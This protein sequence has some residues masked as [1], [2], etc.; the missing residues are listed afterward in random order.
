MAPVR[1]SERLHLQVYQLVLPGFELLLWPWPSSEGPSLT[2]PR[3]DK[4]AAVEVVT[5][6]GSAV[7]Q[8]VASR[9]EDAAEPCTGMSQI[10]AG[11]P[12]IS[13]PKQPVDKTK[14]SLWLIA[15]RKDTIES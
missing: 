6:V 7:Q 14:Q 2:H 13:P 3:L 1:I 5:E 4:E 8:E 12:A 10:N 11:S 9:R 15:V